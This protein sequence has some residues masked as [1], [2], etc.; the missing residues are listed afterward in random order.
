MALL[1]SLGVG[2]LCVSKFVASS[3][4]IAVLKTKDD[5]DGEE[6]VGGGGGMGSVKCRN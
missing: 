6:M 1:G 4:E 3:N 2:V 5:C